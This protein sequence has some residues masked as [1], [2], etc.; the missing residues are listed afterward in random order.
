MRASEYVDLD[1]VDCCGRPMAT[2]GT[3]S[4]PTSLEALPTIACLFASVKRFVQTGH[5]VINIVPN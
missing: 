1:S 2:S 5:T 3:V 4:K